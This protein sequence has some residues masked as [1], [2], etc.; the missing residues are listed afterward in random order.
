LRASTRLRVEARREE[1]R[2]GGGDLV[3]KLPSV[4]ADSEKLTNGVSAFVDFSG[5]SE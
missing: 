2:P 4:V 3:E 5:T 1:D